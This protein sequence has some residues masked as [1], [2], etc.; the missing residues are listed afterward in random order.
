MVKLRNP[1]KLLYR[2]LTLVVFTMFLVVLPTVLPAHKLAA[3]KNVWN[4]FS[5]VTRII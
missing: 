1:R 2:F 3:A 5:N 4:D